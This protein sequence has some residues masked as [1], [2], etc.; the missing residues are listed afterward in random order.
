[1]TRPLSKIP[2]S[3]YTARAK[4][5]LDP[6]DSFIL[7]L[8]VAP[9]Q[10]VCAVAVAAEAG[11]AIMDLQVRVGKDGRVF[12]PHKF[13]AMTVGLHELTSSHLT[14]A[15]LTRPGSTLRQLSLH[16]IPQLV[17]ILLGDLDDSWP[18]PTISSQVARY[19]GEQP[20]RL[21]PATR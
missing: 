18:R 4:R 5:A 1:M 9:L 7:L 8:I 12:N 6:V 3:F 21:I 17:D 2:Q 13:R 11:W 16:K 14:K 19:T 10:V 15:A 20:G